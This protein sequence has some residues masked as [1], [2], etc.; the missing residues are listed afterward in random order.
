MNTRHIASIP[1][2]WVLG[3]AAAVLATTIGVRAEKPPSIQDPPATTAA[4]Q[5]QDEE[6]FATLGEQT[7]EKVC[8][9]CHPWE[10]ITRT[11]R[12]VREWN[13][14]VINM[15]QRGAPGTEPQFAIVKK[16]LTRYYGVVN[17]NAAPA[18]EIA[19]VL[20]LSAK[21]AAAI[22]EYRKAHGKFADAAA[23][24]KVEGIDKAKI[25]EQPEALRF[26]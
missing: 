16:F 17:V 7:T 10:N 26:D 1:P 3:A 24:A 8:I 23:L 12:T 21:D 25:D 2:A 19:A 22:V 14:M 11:R 6:A 13:D 9:I 18:D 15:A 4:K 5:A 20:G